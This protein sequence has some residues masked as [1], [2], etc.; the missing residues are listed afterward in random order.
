MPWSTT[1]ITLTSFVIPVIAIAGGITFAMFAIYLKFRRRRDLLQM[2]HAERMAAIEKGIELPPLSPE[3]L[4]DPAHG[5]CSRSGRRYRGLITLLVGAAITLAMWAQ[6][7]HSFWWGLV[8]VA[9]GAGQL[10]TGLLES[11]GTSA[12][13]G[14]QSGGNSGPTFPGSTPEQ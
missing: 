8:I 6:G 1:L 3:L 2:Y 14:T 5:A 10:V 7:G 4:H 11:A 13:Q 12:Q 9:V